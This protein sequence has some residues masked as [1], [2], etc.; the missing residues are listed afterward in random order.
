MKKILSI[1]ILLFALTSVGLA[2]SNEVVFSGTIAAGA[3]KTFHIPLQKYM[4]KGEVDSV[5][6]SIYY[7]GVIKDSTLT[8]VRGIVNVA[9]YIASSTSTYS[10]DVSYFGTVDTTITPGITNTTYTYT[11]Q[12]YK[13]YKGRMTTGTAQKTYLDGYNA[14]KGVFLA[15]LT[16]NTATANTQN[17]MIVARIFWTKKT[18]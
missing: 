6:L 10:K 7:Q 16:G 17:L 9:E 15:K 18:I 2:Q 5:V 11:P 1:I 4:E 14:I 13:W 3:A 12:I 8:L